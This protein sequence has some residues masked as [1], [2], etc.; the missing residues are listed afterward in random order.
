MGTKIQPISLRLGHSVNWNSNWQSHSEDFADSSFRD[1]QVEKLLKDF[2]S[3]NNILMDKLRVQEYV[4]IN[5]NSHLIFTSEYF[6]ERKPF[7]QTFKKDNNVFKVP[8]LTKGYRVHLKRKKFF[9]KGF[10][11]TVNQIIKVQAPV[12]VKNFLEDFYGEKNNIS[13]SLRLINLIKSSSKHSNEINSNLKRFRGHHRRSLRTPYS[14]DM[15]FL[16]HKSILLQK[17]EMLG[18]IISTLL[19]KS[20]KHHLIL[21]KVE[22]ILKM[23]SP[24]YKGLGGIKIEIK[25]RIGGSKR[26]RRRDIQIG[27]LSLQQVDLPVKYSCHTAVT[28]FGSTSIKVWIAPYTK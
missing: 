27:A 17:T 23:I 21:N 12:L 19:E 10:S 13:F 11:H 25:G 9:R 7:M 26:K 18:D 24:M 28:R 1:S 6:V 2:L 8:Q 3:Q 4:D 5:E 15:Y 16:I 22:Y 14:K 20:K